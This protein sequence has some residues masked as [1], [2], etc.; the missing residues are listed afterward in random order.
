M[1]APLKEFSLEPTVKFRKWAPRLIFFQ[2]LFWGAS[3]WRGLYSDRHLWRKICV[4]KSIRLAYSWKEIYCFF[5]FL[6]CIW[7]LIFGGAYT[8]SGVNEPLHNGVLNITNHISRPSDSKIYGKK[9]G[10]NK[11]SFVILRFHCTYFGSIIMVCSLLQC[12]YCSQGHWDKIDQSARII[13]RKITI[14][15]KKVG[16]G[17]ISSS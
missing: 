10:N 12:D 17:P 15:S 4:S 2:R 11:T 8:W 3:F 7:G 13:Y 1:P 9:P 16:W 6:L 5:F 14:H